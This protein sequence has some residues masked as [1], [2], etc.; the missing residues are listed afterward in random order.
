[1]TGFPPEVI[2]GFARGVS[3][4]F[5]QAAKGEDSASLRFAAQRPYERI[6]AGFLTP[7]DTDLLTG[8]GQVPDDTNY[9]QTNLGFEWCLPLDRIK[10]SDRLLVGVSLSGY[11]R[12]LPSFAEASQ[13]ARF[14]QGA[15]R[16]GECWQR[17]S[18][19]DVDAPALKAEIDVAGL[20]KAGLV[21]IDLSD[22]LVAAW[23]ARAA[24]IGGLYPGRVPLD[25][26]PPDI[27]D[28]A[29][30]Q[31][32]VSQS[33]AGK[34]AA[35]PL[36]R[37]KLDLRV[38]PS[39]T[40][41]N[42]VRV[43]L[44][45][46]NLSEPATQ[47]NS[48]YWDPRL[49]SVAVAATI[50]AHAHRDTEF[51]I[52]PDS[53][54]YN[55][56]VPLIGINCQ[57]RMTRSATLLQVQTEAV[58]IVGGQRLMPREIVGGA[59][60]F[61]ALALADCGLPTLEAIQADMRAYDA[62]VWQQKVESFPDGRERQDAERDR[63]QF[64]SELRSFESGLSLLRLGGE[65]A[66]AFRLMNETM[67][68]LGR[69]R[70]RTFDRWHLFQIVY[71]VGMLPSLIEG[72]EEWKVGQGRLNLLW[73]P[74][75]GGK[76]EAFL[77]LILWQVF[78]DRLRGKAF[79]ITAFLRYP[80]RL[81]TYQQ[82]QRIC[83][84]LGKAE[85]VR[86]E[87]GI[88][89]D[90]FSVGYLVG[91]TTTPNRI[92]DEL[93]Q[94]L[95]SGVPVDWQRVFACPT[96]DSRTVLLRYNESLRLVEHFC[97][98][99]G[100][101]AGKK[102]LPLY[103]CDD[104]LYRYLPTVVV[105]TVDKLAG[106]GQ[107]RRFAQL[108]GRIDM[109]CPTHGAAFGGS[110]GTLCEASRELGA[111]RTADTCGGLPLLKSPF[112][113]LSPSL[114]IQD[115][116]HLLRE[117]LATFDAHY[118]TAAM[119]VQR[120]L[121]SS[122]SH[123]TLIG[124]TATIEG[125]REQARHLYLSDAVRFPSPGPEAYESFYYTADPTRLG[126]MFVG[127]LGVGRT[128][129]PTVA[130]TIGLLHT[131]VEQIRADCSRDPDAVRSRLG[132]ANA[133]TQN[134]IDLCFHYEVVLT[135][136]LTRKGGDQVGEAIDSRVRS[137]I[138]TLG[139]AEL[140]VE[141]FNGSVDMPR[142]IGTMEEIEDSSPDTPLGERI[143]GVVATN[144][145]SHGVDIDRFNLM[146]FAGLPRQFAEYIQASAR[147]GRQLPG[148]AVLVVTPQAERDRSVLDRFDKCHEYVDRLVEPV[149]I[150]RWSEPALALTLRG[151]LAAYLMGVASHRLG[152]EVYLVR[153]V[154]D[155]FGQPGY[156]A[157]SEDAVLRWV[158]EA[159]GAQSDDAPPGFA[160]AARLLTA[161][162]YGGVTGA[163]AD[164][165]KQPL[166]SHLEAMRSLRDIDEPGYIRLPSQ[167]ASDLRRMGI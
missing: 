88:T 70:R 158:V 37:P 93:H 127:L 157:L 141:S 159:I 16:V 140:R 10:Q 149:P 9:E 130:R 5:A 134:L 12:S 53:Y 111:G 1:M 128:H 108:F 86:R 107:N 20:V 106:L 43:L 165:D 136:V 74:A 71:I 120:E 166:N 147:V 4:L 80:L 19:S 161:R 148:I 51:R 69:G 39:P 125:Y 54:R 81:L 104:D 75:G 98:A 102:R 33:L 38:F 64:R 73:F 3:G 123:W 76:T 41:H 116:L 91:E 52:L 164:H 48:A 103:I 6:L 112:K 18:L 117:A 85:L 60:L 139:G 144:I 151:V 129:T 25:L 24:S 15:W 61:A 99:A 77:G 13:D 100:C 22:Q 89:G 121:S 21:E 26:H 155:N 95:R 142:M 122:K 84:A 131:L 59:P 135:Y 2:N 36:W 156:E 34:A 109:C 154:R 31:A 113:H 150:N 145:I 105:S 8:P 17:V 50:P 110:N 63:E 137:E 27:A 160:E 55:R 68:R 94:K 146:V 72:S 46:V 162:L 163:S 65:V 57:P 47:T 96:C 92:S 23:R 29:S 114:H 79:G 115:E 119:A 45:V 66:T 101:A 132:M 35:A 118:E 153:H 78:R 83:R 30:Y 58:P 49:Y 32:W 126:R 7:V 42:A 62:N 44:R 40:E 56:A 14:R 11:V 87:A 152:R 97:D 124:S 67:S 167:D 133:M 82:L 143:R 90:P 28:E 138:E